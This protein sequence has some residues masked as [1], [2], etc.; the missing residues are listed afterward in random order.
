M[1]ENEV[2]IRVDKAKV[3]N[4]Q[5]VGGKAMNEDLFE[6]LKE[7]TG[8]TYISD[9]RY[10]P[11]RENAI[12]ILASKITGGGYSLHTWND[13]LQYLLFHESCSSIEEAKRIFVRAARLL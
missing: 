5:F 10:S 2:E 11:Y 1:P 3:G 13:A 12:R 7:E 4:M 6:Y 9:L 8:A